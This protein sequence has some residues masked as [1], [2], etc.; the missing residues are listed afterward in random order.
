[1]ASMHLLMCSFV[2]KDV[3]K[4]GVKKGLNGMMVKEILQSL[5]DD[6][7]VRQ[8]KIGISNYFW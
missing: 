7:L 2:L 4:A 6:D 8:E 5:V 1:M 3:E